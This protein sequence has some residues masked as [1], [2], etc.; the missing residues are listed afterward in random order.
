MNEFKREERYVVFKLSKLDKNEFVRGKQLD[1]LGNSFI[2]DARVDC[3]VVESDW[4]EYEPAWS[5][6]ERRITG[7]AK[8]VDG[9]ALECASKIMDHFGAPT[10][11]GGQFQL[12]AIVQLEV[13]TA[14]NKFYGSSE[15]LQSE[16]TRAR[17]LLTKLTAPFG[18]RN[19]D[20]LDEASDYLAHQSAPAE[21][22][23][24][25]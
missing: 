24:S 18:N 21:K 15:A 12:K 23:D 22:E 25:E 11:I 3:L 13:I 16:L 8:G 9:V 10:L 7:F 2:A 4:P 19:P 5:M 1:C 6:L 14:L 20:Y 17:K